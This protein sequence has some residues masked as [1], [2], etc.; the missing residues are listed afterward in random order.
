MQRHKQY[1]LE[2]YQEIWEDHKANFGKD[3]EPLFAYLKE[4]G[5]GEG[6]GVVAG[7][8]GKEK[9][10]SISLYHERGHAEGE[11]GEAGGAGEEISFRRIWLI[12]GFGY[13]NFYW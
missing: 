13:S 4:K 5:L 3:H 2:Q 9:G 1:A 11:G 10:Y 7:G 12:Q 8:A 6:G